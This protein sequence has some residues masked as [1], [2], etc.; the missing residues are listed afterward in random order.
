MDITL[1]PEAHPDS[2]EIS[3]FL[4]ELDKE[5]YVKTPIQ[6]GLIFMANLT[7]KENIKICQ[8]KTDAGGRLAFPYSPL[9]PG[10][11][12]YWFIF[13]PLSAA[14]GA[15]DEGLAAREICL[16]ST[17]LDYDTLIALAPPACQDVAPPAAL[18]NYPD[19]ILAH[20]ELYF[21]NKVPR[22]YA[23]LCWPLMLILG[24]LLGA[25]FAVGRNPFA[26]FDLSSP[27]LARGRQY[28]ARVQNKS[29][30]LLGYLMAAAQA[31]VSAKDMK[32]G[33]K[34]SKSEGK[35]G[36]GGFMKQDM[37]STFG[38]GGGQAGGKGGTGG[39]DRASEKPAYSARA[40]ATTGVTQ[41]L[42]GTPGAD[43]GSFAGLIKMVF[44][45]TAK[46][47]KR[48]KDRKERKNAQAGTDTKQTRQKQMAARNPVQ[49]KMKGTTR[50]D[51]KDEKN[52]LK[53]D[54]SLSRDDR[55]A[56]QVQDMQSSLSLQMG[57]AA[58]DAKE[59]GNYGDAIGYTLAGFSLR[60]KDFGQSLLAILK[61][62][63]DVVLMNYGMDTQS[64]GDLFKKGSWKG[65]KPA[66]KSIFKIIRLLVTAYSI[67]CEI[68]NYTKTVQGLAGKGGKA[69]GYMDDFSENELF[70]VGN[71]N[72]STNA[73]VGFVNPQ[74]ATHGT[75]PSVPYPFG[76]IVSPV[77]G[78]LNLG[79]DAIATGI[80]NAVA[81][82]DYGRGAGAPEAMAISEHGRYGVAC[83]DTKD[84]K[85]NTQYNFYIYKSGRMV[86]CSEEDI[87]R[88][89][90]ANKAVLQGELP[91][92]DL[93][94]I[95]TG[96]KVGFYTSKGSEDGS[97]SPVSS[98]SGYRE[99]LASRVELKAQAVQYLLTSFN[100]F[101][102]QDRKEAIFTHSRALQHQATAITASFQDEKGA[103]HYT[104]SAEDLNFAQ[105][106]V[107]ITRFLMS[108]IQVSGDVDEAIRIAEDIQKGGAM[109]KELADKIEKLKGELSS[110]TPGSSNY[111]VINA[112]I[113][114]L[115]TKQGLAWLFSGTCVIDENFKQAKGIVKEMLSLRLDITDAACG[116]YLSAT[117]KEHKAIIAGQFG[118]LNKQFRSF[119]SPGGYSGYS[120]K[121][122]MAQMRENLASI[123]E[124]AGE[125]RS[126]L[127]ALLEMPVGEQLSAAAKSLTTLMTE[128]NNKHMSAEKD[129]GNA[130]VAAAQ[131]K[132]DFYSQYA[133][134]RGLSALAEEGARLSEPAMLAS[135]GGAAID[136]ALSQKADAYAQKVITSTAFSQAYSSQNDQQAADFIAALP[137][138]RSDDRTLTFT[139]LGGEKETI[140]KADLRRLRQD[141]TVETAGGLILSIDNAFRPLH[142]E[143]KSD[144]QRFE[145]AEHTITAAA[146]ALSKGEPIN[147][148]E[149]TIKTINNYLSSPDEAKLKAV[150]QIANG[151]KKDAI[152]QDKRA[153][154]VVYVLKP[155]E[156]KTAPPTQP[157]MYS[158]A[159]G[160]KSQLAYELRGR[161]ND[162]DA[163]AVQA[164]IDK[165]MKEQTRENFDE[166]DLRMQAGKEIIPA[167]E[168]IAASGELPAGQS[169]AI[170]EAIGNYRREPGHET[171]DRV[172]VEYGNV[173]NYF[174]NK[175]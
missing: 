44:G 63:A 87:R 28:T 1:D 29:F 11:T 16:N 53:A 49:S 137:L 68:S 146:Q 24:L 112:R 21:C 95:A 39:Q 174:I 130:I 37:K 42:L 80:D 14:S 64:V 104:A 7:D 110:A 79:V 160:W 168:G 150:E 69:R 106:Y 55:Q 149:T 17:G 113:M 70:K 128:T 163:K 143:P 152:K 51:F 165:Y 114:E 131:A 124:Q 129:K 100:F 173:R 54:G 111:N 157:Q 57:K 46:G 158:T 56:L 97:L 139:A 48:R 122:T 133:S 31:G 72:V 148:D 141:G 136:Q 76:F 62:L 135:T 75:A 145:N 116:A 4:F 43:A 171:L 19:H 84:D 162:E 8:T 119:T 102:G 153:T 32:S 3:V 88:A 59:S 156:G 101:M 41:S 154:D 35:S 18:A 159:I 144:W 126:A 121:E 9:A 6:D 125:L 23:P 15:S 117:S 91:G 34:S 96:G 98:E 77:L 103:V 61:L 58:A 172:L 170:T 123:S 166:V 132:A 26:A 108:Q 81:G 50:K 82:K 27:R 25:S 105:D 164:A 127:P 83:A 78:G 107:N 86:Q 13:C 52:R 40:D 38:F 60:G 67:V 94:N 71:Y 73:L 22:D 142:A 109:A 115:E 20:N 66:V 118:D 2:G 65:A 5:E 89:M 90:E 138:N 30:D 36:F 167:L 175:K 140:T 120:S 151:M 85:G 134:S 47:D 169:S 93:K 45:A 99:K 92:N 10:C 161:I 155:E 33:M 147:I 74:L 12:D